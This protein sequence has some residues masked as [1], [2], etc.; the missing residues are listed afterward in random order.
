M[1]DG[2]EQSFPHPSLSGPRVDRH[3]LSLAQPQG[4][5]WAPKTLLA[6][7]SQ[8]TEAIVEVAGFTWNSPSWNRAFGGRGWGVPDRVLTPSRLDSCAPW[9]LVQQTLRRGPWVPEM[10]LGIPQPVAHRREERHT[11]R[12]RRAAVS[13]GGWPGRGSGV[14]PDVSASSRSL[15]TAQGRQGL[16]SDAKLQADRA[17]QDEEASLSASLQTVRR[18]RCPRGL[19]PSDASP[20][21][22]GNASLA[23]SWRE[24]DKSHRVALAHRWHLNQILGTT[25]QELDLPPATPTTRAVPEPSTFRGSWGWGDRTLLRP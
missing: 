22:N 10:P 4:W 12:L 7:P 1:E 17:D 24:P 20:S 21:P 16:A 3:S 9:C 18:A 8:L 6:C 25:A 11:S 14:K 5:T 2:S 23:A 15:V 13:Q 19:A